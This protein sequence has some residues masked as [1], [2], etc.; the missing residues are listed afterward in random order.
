MANISFGASVVEQTGRSITRD[1][2]GRTCEISFKGS[3]T[4]LVAKQP[5]PGDTL[6]ELSDG[7]FKVTS[8]KLVRI[9]GNDGTL[10][11]SLFKPASA[12]DGGG[13]GDNESGGTTYE[14][15][16]EQINRPIEMHPYFANYG[17]ASNG[18]EEAD[19]ARVEDALA[20]R[21]M[22]KRQEAV[23]ALA[24][25]ALELYNKKR[26]GVESYNVYAPTIVETSYATTK[27]VLNGGN[28]REQ[29]PAD[30]NFPIN[31]GM[32]DKNQNF[33]PYIYLRMPDQAAKETKR[34][35]ITRTWMGFTDL[36]PIIY[37]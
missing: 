19:L 33:I 25:G 22:A 7:E 26:Q 36:D 16:F 34:W 31:S 35:R 27:P 1:D 15:R 10:D 28:R 30:S 32:K 6:A 24:G 2:K 4:D 37:P 3:Y 29:P 20:A 18:I 17:S 9:N 21:D 11:V 13:G 12:D 23:A 8:S 14:V 5:S